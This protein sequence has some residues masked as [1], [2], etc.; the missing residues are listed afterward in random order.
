MHVIVTCVQEGLFSERESQ[1]TKTER[2]GIEAAPYLLGLSTG[3]IGGIEGDDLH[4]LLPGA[5][6]P[7]ILLL[8][9]A[10]LRPP[11]TPSHG[12][13]TT[14]ISLC[15]KTTQHFTRPQKNKAYRV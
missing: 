15:S 12:G 14:P 10:A 5:P 3:E 2:V 8:R 1:R 11:G 6:E 7:A 9:P 4:T 13:R